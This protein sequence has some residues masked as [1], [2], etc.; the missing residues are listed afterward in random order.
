MPRKEIEDD[1]R[2]P[3]SSRPAGWGQRAG[4]AATGLGQKGAVWSK[5]GGGMGSTGSDNVRFS[6]LPFSAMMVKGI[7]ATQA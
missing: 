7:G 2:L 5:D 3:R 6:K 1:D 4:C